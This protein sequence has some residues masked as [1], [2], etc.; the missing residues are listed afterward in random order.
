MLFEGLLIMVLVTCTVLLIGIPAYKMIRELIP[1][2]ANPLADAKIRLEVARQEIEA[3]RLNK[4]AEKIYN[5]LY[6]EV[7]QDDQESDRKKL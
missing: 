6:E 7:L 3:A 5:S 2:K 1:K 4:E